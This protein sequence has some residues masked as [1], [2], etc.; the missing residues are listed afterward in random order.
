[1]LSLFRRASDRPDT[2]EASHRGLVR[3]LMY[4]VDLE[5]YESFG[6]IDASS[7]VA[8][9]FPFVPSSACETHMACK[10]G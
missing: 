5:D 8:D 2:L 6:L 4:Q 7:L 9:K 1:M 3:R 10:L